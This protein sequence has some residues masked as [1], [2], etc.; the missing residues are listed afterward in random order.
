MVFLHLTSLFSPPTAEPPEAPT[1]AAPAA[2]PQGSCLWV[3]MTRPEQALVPTLGAGESS[4]S[5]EQVLSLNSE[6]WGCRGD[7]TPN[8]IIHSSSEGW[9][10][11][12]RPVTGPGSL[13]LCGYMYNSILSFRL[14]TIWSGSI[15]WI[16]SEPPSPGLCGGSRLLLKEATCRRPLVTKPT[17]RGHHGLAAVPRGPQERADNQCIKDLVEL[18]LGEI[19]RTAL[20]LEDRWVPGA[21]CRGGGQ[22][23]S[24]GRTGRGLPC[25]SS[26]L[27]AST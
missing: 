22:G 24:C 26:P 16:C 18:C 9:D 10:S 3:S 27:A 7:L 23:F 21:Q 13:T 6:S 1:S 5:P 17:R 20:A 12:Q 25:V 11:C 4:W 8:A 15:R 2:S 19:R 14:L